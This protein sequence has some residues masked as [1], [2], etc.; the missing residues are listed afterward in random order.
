MVM[1]DEIERPQQY[2]WRGRLALVLV[3]L[4]FGLF[5]GLTVLVAGGL[6]AVGVLTRTGRPDAS[7]A[8]TPTSASLLDPSALRSDDLFDDATGVVN[9]LLV[10]SEGNDIQ[11][12]G[13]D[14][15]AVRSL[16]SDA[17]PQHSYGQPTWAPDAASVAWSELHL[18]DTGAGPSSALYHQRLN[19]SI[20]RRVDTGPFLPFYIYFDPDS[21]RIA[22]LS[23][24]EDG[25]ALR[26]VVLNGDKP[27][28]ALVARDRCG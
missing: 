17:S 22:M 23:N 13:P 12:I 20:A 16:T 27:E 7:V 25:L 2:P 21:L 6:A 8:L 3:I 5:A 19:D 4:V 10:Q 28:A 11:L 26:Y 15:G 9:L 14:G 18:E 1:D 24:W